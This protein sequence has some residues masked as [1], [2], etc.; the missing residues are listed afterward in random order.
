MTI[1]PDYWL[2]WINLIIAYSLLLNSKILDRSQ[3]KS[4]IDFLYIGTKLTVCY[5]LLFPMSSDLIGHI[6]INYWPPYLQMYSTFTTVLVLFTFIIMRINS[7]EMILR[8]IPLAILFYISMHVFQFLLLGDIALYLLL[9]FL[10]VGISLIIE[11]SLHVKNKKK[12]F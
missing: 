2:F 3:L 11:L 12:T 9:M 1:R 5:S 10:Y 7:L 6:T 4:R 8:V